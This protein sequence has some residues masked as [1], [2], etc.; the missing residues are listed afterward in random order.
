MKKN[1]LEMGKEIQNSKMGN[2]F[3]LIE[4]LVVIAIITILAGLLIPT[5]KKAKDSA[6][7]TL[8]MSNLKQLGSGMAFY[9]ENY[10]GWFPSLDYG[11]STNPRFFYNLVDYELTGKEASVNSNTL[12]GTKLGIWLCPSVSTDYASKWSYMGLH[13]GYNKYLGYYSRNAAAVS[14]Q[15][16]QVQSVRRPYEIIMLADSDGDKD[17]DSILDTTY[18]TVGY[19]HNM[20]SNIAFVDLHVEWKNLFAVSRSGIYW[21]GVRWTG[22]LDSE[23]VLRMWGKAGRYDDP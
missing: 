11:D 23:A 5:L 20:G 15:K 7:R 19:R 12:S 18:Y 16:V 6:N 2:Y 3:T 22:G 8:C 4:L 1:R 17:Y 13:Y 9:L 21:T 14:T 10:K